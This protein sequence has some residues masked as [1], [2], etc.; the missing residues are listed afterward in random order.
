MAFTIN[1]T[2]VGKDSKD[3]V[4]P[5]LMAGRTLAVPTIT[6][7]RNVNYKTRIT[8]I[9]MSGLVKKATCAFDPAGTVAID[10]AWLD[11]KNLEVNLELC[12]K[13]LMADFIGSDMG[14]GDPAPADFLRYLI[15]EIGANVAD[16]IE[17]KIWQGIDGANS[18]E[19]FETLFAADSTVVKVG[20]P[21]AITP[22]N[23][24]DEVRRGIALIPAK[25]LGTS[26]LYLYASTTVYQALRQANNDKNAASPCGEDCMNIDGIT[27]QLAPGMKAGS[28]AFAQKS[29]MFFG[30]W[31]SSDLANV[32]VKD[33]SEFLEDN[34]RFGMCFFAGVAYGYGAEIVYYA[35]A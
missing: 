19:G 13:D 12:K 5:A 31:E 17:T 2:Y 15:A 18:F 28:Y 23:V 22:A 20:T 35:G 21:I 11:V 25:L 33:M 24:I 3:F 34:V 27:V 6:I 8:K 32:K 26:D 4:S 7:K 14:C 16:D 9:N 10:E 29:N 30:T 1:S